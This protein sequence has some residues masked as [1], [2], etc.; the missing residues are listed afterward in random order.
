VPGEKIL[1]LNLRYEPTPKEAAET[2]TKELIE[3]GEGL[4][5]EVPTG[6]IPDRVS[7]S[8]VRRRRAL[9][10]R[11]AASLRCPICSKKEVSALGPPQILPD[12][13]EHWDI[14][15]FNCDEQN[16]ARHQF[17]RFPSD[18]RQEPCPE[19]CPHYGKYLG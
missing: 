4:K 17:H 11:D 1:N 15:C 8:A 6:P 13:S 10:A 7:S 14:S 18:D 16:G 5:V 12:G 19:S 2:A 3:S 9:N